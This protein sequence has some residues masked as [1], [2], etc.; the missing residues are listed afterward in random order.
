MRFWFSP[1]PLPGA[2][3]SELAAAG[4]EPWPNDQGNPHGN[5][6]L[7]VYDSP[8]RHIDA[9]AWAEAVLSSAALAEGYSK[10]LGHRE[11]SGQPLMA[12]WRLQQVGGLGL[13]QWL[14]GNSPRVEVGEAEPINPL[15]A[16]VILSLLDTQPQ[17]L[18]IY[19]ELELQAEL[20]GSD[21]DLNYRQRLQQ[22]I[23]QADPLLKLLAALQTHEG[24]L[25][26][27][28]DENVVTKLRLQQVQEELRDLVLANR[29]TQQL[30]DA[31][32]KELECLEATIHAL[33]QEL[34][35]KVHNLEQQLKNRDRELKDAREDSELTLL[36]LHQVQEELE[37]QLQ[38]RDRDLSEARD[39]A[40]L[41]LLQLHQVQEELERYYLQARACSPLVEAQA[42]QLHRSKRLLAKVAMS[43]FSPSGDLATIAVEVLPARDPMRHGPSM[44]VQALLHAYAS[45]LDRASV[46]LSRAMRR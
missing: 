23:A 20:L 28:L 14:A 25:Q 26:D 10:L 30:L 27:A 24:K 33:K 17:L 9:A 31:R 41:T 45:N 46:L 5:T 34:Q 12:G 40:G 35:P 44:Q 18:E 8:E 39:D 29:Q 42:D 37:Q 43:D 6:C 38:N 1:L 19:N 11:D 4:L 7:L 15:I 13:Q 22:A 16:S 21:A 36:Q 32:N 3:I 2:V